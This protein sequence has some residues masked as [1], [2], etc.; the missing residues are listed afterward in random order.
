MCIII[1]MKKIRWNSPV[2]LSF[3]L[4][5]GIVLGLNIL[6]HGYTNRMFFSVYASSPTNPLFYVRLIGHVLGH[7]SLEHYTSNMI[8]F[9]LVGPLLEEKYGSGKLLSIIILVAVITGLVHIFIKGNSALLGASGVDFAFMILASITGSTN[10]HSIPL[11]FL[12]VAAIYIVQQV[13]T[14]ITAHDQI[15]QLTHIVG[16]TVGAIYGLFLNKK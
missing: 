7:A 3:A 10:D 9:L 16:G 2:I 15:S 4:L 12:I 13:F 1:G 6:T 11:T 8:L 5:S 14:G